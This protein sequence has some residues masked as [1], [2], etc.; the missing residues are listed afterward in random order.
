MKSNWAIRWYFFTGVKIRCT[1]CGLQKGQDDFQYHWWGFS[2]PTWT[3]WLTLEQMEKPLDLRVSLD[4]WLAL[5]PIGCPWTIGVA[6]GPIETL[7]ALFFSLLTDKWCF[8]FSFHFFSFLGNFVW[9]ILSSHFLM[10]FWYII[11][12][13]FVL[14]MVGIWPILSCLQT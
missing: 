8:F 4:S 12:F 2:L 14:S 9:L 7:R 11:S 3:L 6:L 13:N 1:F 5:E 10:S